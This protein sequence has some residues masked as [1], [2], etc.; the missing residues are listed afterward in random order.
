MRKIDV[1][2][3]WYTRVW[4]EADLT[5]IDAF[6]APRAGAEGLMADGRV[7]PEDFRALVPALRALVRDLGISIDT[8]QEVGDWLWAQITV[9]AL[10]AAGT[11]PIRACGQVMLRF[12]DGLIAEA[13]NSF[14]FLTF[15]TQ[16]GL[17]PDDAF[18]LLLAGERLD[19][20]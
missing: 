20:A 11:R 18:L 7:G 6:F 5:A 15:F 17:L 8:W 14:D 9:S 1:L 3:D 16:A 4:I 10:P 12:R 19:C 2:R 13:Y